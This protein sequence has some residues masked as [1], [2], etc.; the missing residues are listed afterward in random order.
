MMSSRRKRA[1]VAAAVTTVLVL[2]GLASVLRARAADTPKRDAVVVPATSVTV[3]SPTVERWPQ[4]LQ[5]NGAVAAWQEA[6]IAAEYGGL[7]I[8]AIYVDVG[9]KVKRGQ[10]LAQLAD[11]T[12]RADLA[13]QQATVAQARAAL[14]QSHANVERGKAVSGSGALSAQT[15]EGYRATDDTAQATL[16]GALADLKTKQVQLAQTRIVAVDDGIV[17]SRSALLGNVVASGA[18]LFRIVRQSRIEWQA[19]LDARQLSQVA[20]GQAAQ[21]Q[22]AGGR[23]VNGHVRLVGPTISS[24]TG[25]AIAYVALDAESGVQPGFYGS[26]RI[27]GP[28]SSATT[29]PQSALVLRDGRSDVYVVVPPA[30]GSPASQATASRR[31]VVTGR[32]RGDRV[33]IVSGLPANAQV[34]SSGG[35]F[36]SEGKAIQVAQPATAPLEARP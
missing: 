1:F 31:V 8:A 29:L 23:A 10:L 22:G 14:V 21:L 28:E 20:V 6:V 34:V 11:D 9:S 13:K 4:T 27:D 30:A 12:L 26:G 25:R 36:L 5:A 7:R 18:E 15:I 24:T 33:E 32:R 19:E 2:A 35:A 17:S 3:V 16:D